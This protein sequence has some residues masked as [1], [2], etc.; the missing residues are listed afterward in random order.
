MKAI[1]IEGGKGDASALRLADVPVPVVPDGKMLIRVRA[2]GVNRPDLFQRM[3]HYPAPPGASAVLGLEVAGEVVTAVGRWREGDKVCALLSGGGYAEYAVCDPRHALPVPA[4]LS[5]VQAASLPETVIT[6]FAN[7]IGDGGLRAGETL[8]IHGA[9]SGIGVM[10]IQI[11][12]ALGARV[13]ATARGSEKAEA[14]RTLGADV[15]VDATIDDFAE[16]TVAAGGGRRRCG[17]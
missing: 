14:A 3:G 16:V 8:L 12:K 5:F 10:A 1:E 17:A 15:A 7:M 11:A 6:V 2:A 13:I 4:A 9:T